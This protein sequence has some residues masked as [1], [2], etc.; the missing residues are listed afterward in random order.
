MRNTTY[1][2]TLTVAVEHNTSFETGTN[3]GRGGKVRQICWET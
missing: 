3:Q 2:V 1:I